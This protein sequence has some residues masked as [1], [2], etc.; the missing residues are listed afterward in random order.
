MAKTVEKLDLKTIGSMTGERQQEYVDKDLFMAMSSRQFGMKFLQTGC[1][2]RLEEGRVMR[3]LSGKASCF[4]NLQP[5]T[6]LPQTLFVIPANSVFEIESYDEDFDVQVFSF[7]DL[8]SEATFETCTRLCLKKDDWELI[9]EYFHLL[10]REINA[11]P[12][13]S[14]TIRHL[15]TALLMRLRIIRQGKDT[16]MPS[17]PSRPYVLFQRFL[18]LLN[19]YGI[20]ERSIPFYAGRLCVTPNHLGFVVKEASGLT[21]MQWVNRHLI[22]QAK[23]ELKYSDTPVWEI[24]EKFNFPNPG[25]FAK[26]FRRETGMSPGEYRKR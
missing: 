19:E 24:A 12:P 14:A 3:I 8:P 15:Q 10:W 4:I 2:Y 7:L 25:F 11:V 6:L 21:V 23:I 9:D 17:S 22:Q 1:P 16:D 18:D 13:A 20:R 26:F 5:Y